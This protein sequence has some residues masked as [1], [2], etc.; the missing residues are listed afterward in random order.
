MPP[1]KRRTDRNHTPPPYATERELVVIAKPDARLTTDSSGIASAVGMDITPLQELTAAP[2]VTMVPMFGSE[3]H[4][5]ASLADNPDLPDL[6]VFYRVTAPDDRLDSLAESMRAAEVVEAA[7]VKPGA[8]PPFRADEMVPA[9][10][11]GPPAHTPDFVSRQGYLDPAPG[12]VDARH[13]WTVPGGRGANVN[14]IDIEGAWQFGHEDL[15]ANQG[16]V[17]GGTPTADLGWRNHGTAVVGEFGGDANLFGITGICPDANVRAVSFFGIGTGA[18]IKT[19]AD[20][21]RPGDVLII[22]L[23][24]AGPRFGFEN[25]QDQRGFIPIEWWEDD[26]QAIR[27]AVARGVVVVSAAGNGAENLDDALYSTRPAGFPQTWRNPFDRAARDSG[28]VLVG[29]G[30]PPPGTHGRDHGPDRSRLDF[31]NWGSAVD[32]QAWGREVTTTGGL[33]GQAGDLQGGPNENE[34]Y[35][36][37]FSGTSSATP[38]VT[39]VLSSV[40]GALRAAGRIPLTPARARAELRAAGSPQTD[41]PNR[42][43]TQRIGNRP[44]L[45]AMLARVSQ[46]ASIWTGTQ[47]TGSLAPG[48]TACWFTFNWP[49]HWYVLWTVVPVT[50]QTGSPQIRWRTRV[51]R[52]SD[53]YA[54]YWICVSNLTQSQVAFEGRYAVLG[55]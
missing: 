12:G 9:A 24:R 22:E 14:I 34:W 45:R 20:H 15:I 26:Y 38:I 36:D 31:S 11:E 33:S 13:A 42:P 10:K 54:T 41:A 25:R 47:F 40:Q 5:R 30:A 1:N 7:Y 18:A 8:L 43:R 29:A 4:V 19:A 16:G 27:Y 53:T 3:E 52:A 44:D 28:S 37:R 35:T 6:S 49:A 39:G 32:V 51:E 55:W 17:V 48:Q 23:H 21:L 50:P 46:P 2:D